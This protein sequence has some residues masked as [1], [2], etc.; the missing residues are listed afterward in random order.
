MSTPSA[1]LLATLRPDAAGVVSW[2]H[3]GDLHMT[4]RDAQ[5]YYDFLSLIEEVNRGMAESM[6]FAYLPGDNAD[7]GTAQE[8]ESVRSALSVLRIPYFAIVGDH[9]ARGRSF[10]NFRHFLMPD[11]YYYFSVGQVRFFALNAFAQEDPERFDVSIEQ[12]EWLQWHLDDRAY[13]DG[14]SVLFLHCYPSE[15]TNHAVALSNM[16]RNY[17]VLLVDMGHT[18]YNEIANDG[19][20]LYTATRSTGQV[21]EGPVGVSITNID[22]NVVS[23]KFKTLG[24]WPLAMITSPADER[25]ITDRMMPNEVVRDDVKI[26]VKAWSDVPVISCSLSV[27]N[28]VLQPIRQLADSHVWESDWNS[29]EV[30]DGVHL[31]QAVVTDAETKRATDEIR[32]VVS[33]SGD[34]RR[35][36]HAR[37]DQDNSLGAWLE[38]GVLGTQL[39]P[40][41][42]GRKW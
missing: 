18:H 12:L 6:A 23:W 37:R 7:H 17:R 35:P 4:T 5:N 1:N 16:I 33:Q 9:D 25:L 31:L 26:R 13:R 22:S 20:T 30:G 11:M 32:V 27:D 40:N 29:Q 36:E 24:E 21:E 19:R 10:D 3:F 39:G 41:K 34:F 42:N 28:E 2:V 8:Y 15:L 14:K 38:R